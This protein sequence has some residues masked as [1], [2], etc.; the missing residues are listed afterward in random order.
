[1]VGS[2]TLGFPDTRRHAFVWKSGVMKDLGAIVGGNESSA[3]G[4][5][6]DGVIV[7]FSQNS[8]G[9]MRAVRW[10]P[11][12]RKLSLGTLGGR[13]SEAKAINDFGV[14]V[15]WSQI[16]GGQRHAFRYENGVMT[17]LGTMEGAW[18]EA[19]DINNGGAIVG[20]SQ[21]DPVSAM[22]SSGKPALLKTLEPAPPRATRSSASP[23]R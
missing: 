22:P 3:N 2:S 18:S 13:N 8:A 23:W 21:V 4:I 14:I 20:Y 15:G 10:M 6:N 11:D 19:N 12:G 17:D 7:G 1:M 5:N 16:A 9:D